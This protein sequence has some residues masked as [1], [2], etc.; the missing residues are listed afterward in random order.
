MTPRYRWMTCS[1]V[2]V[3]IQGLKED[4]YFHYCLDHSHSSRQEFCPTLPTDDS[5][6][7]FASLKASPPSVSTKLRA[8]LKLSVHQ[9]TSWKNSWEAQVITAKI[10]AIFIKT[11]I[12][13]F[14]LPL[15]PFPETLCYIPLQAPHINGWAVSRADFKT[16]TQNGIYPYTC[17]AIITMLYSAPF[18]DYF[19][20]IFQF[21]KAWF[22]LNN[23]NKK[24]V[25][26]KKT[27]Q[28]CSQYRYISLYS[29]ISYVPA[30]W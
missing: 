24:R 17:P 18:W 25:F 5:S 20:S 8:H 15:L 12:A 4:K 2:F 29:Q 23:N 14:L 11:N 6:I 10:Q 9:T 21:K 30:F 26:N 13:N 3:W 28:N 7:G 1:C 19:P 22:F 16:T 27:L